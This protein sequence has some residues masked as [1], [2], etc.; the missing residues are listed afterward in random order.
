MYNMKN[1][2]LAYLYLIPTILCSKPSLVANP[3]PQGAI[4]PAENFIDLS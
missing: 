2:Q 1:S 3:D 4:I